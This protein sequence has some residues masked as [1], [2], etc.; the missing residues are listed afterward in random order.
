MLFKLDTINGE[1]EVDVTAS[2][3]LVMRDA[4]A[5]TLV[6][7]IEATQGVA[8]P[9]KP[10]IA[11]QLGAQ[12]GITAGSTLHEALNATRYIGPSGA[13]AATV[14]N[15]GAVTGRLVTQAVLFDA[16]ENHLREDLTGY[17][18]M[19]SDQ[20]AL[21]RSVDGT[22]WETPILDFRRPEGARPEP[23]AQLSEP[24][25]MITLKTSMKSNQIMGEAI[26]IEY[27]DEVAKGLTLDVVA[28]SLKRAASETA[29]RLAMYQ[30][31][32]LLNGDVDYSIRPLVEVLG[33]AAVRASE[34]DA[35]ATGGKLTQTAWIKWLWRNNLKRTITTVI[36][37]LPGALAIE[38]REGRP[39][40]ENEKINSNRIDTFESVLNP[41]WADRVD[42]IITQDPSW[43]A[44]MI[45]GFD[46]Q[47]GYNYITSTATNY[48][49]TE[50]LVIR[51]STKMRFDTGSMVE[52]FMD[53]AWD[54][55]SLT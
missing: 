31:M 14:G 11:A 48:S 43:P 5:S 13:E 53:D 39:K 18:K 12:M 33:G 7:H 30:I 45:V 41:R 15:D 21:K 24:T 1:R 17:A 32:T 38:N 28:L 47:Y 23:I 46:K 4:Q 36:T 19:L 26:G 20:A 34:L 35:A 3:H 2:T 6:K 52:R 54:A 9:G 55:L 27:S 51:R 40:T 37:D 44:G 25:R 8:A 49:A 16:I 22:R 50:E 42:V 29:A 10:S